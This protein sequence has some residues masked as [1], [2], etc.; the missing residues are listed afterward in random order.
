MIG[1]VF[2]FSLPM[3][4][5]FVLSVFIGCHRSKEVRKRER[6]RKRKRERERDLCFFY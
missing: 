5:P 2:H 1:Q 3:L 4:L 6:E